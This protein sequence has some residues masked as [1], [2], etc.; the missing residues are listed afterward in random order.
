MLP[1][2]Y[3]QKGK[4]LPNWENPI[5]HAVIANN[6]CF[7]SGQLSVN[8]QGKFVSG[9]LKEEA[10][11]AFENFFAVLTASGFTKE[12]VVFVDIA[13]DNLQGMPIIDQLYQVYFE[14]GK[15]PARTVYQVEALPFDGKIKIMG[16]AVKDH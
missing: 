14:A 11:R 3:I 9:T 16:T 8:V 1:K 15:S 6:M 4:G 13:F 2:K 7:V 12:D 10:K 5:S